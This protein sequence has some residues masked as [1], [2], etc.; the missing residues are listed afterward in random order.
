MV[1]VPK[2]VMTHIIIY[3]SSNLNTAQLEFTKLR[4]GN[5]RPVP[6]E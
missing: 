3:M 5:D 4:D 1:F 2:W 6:F